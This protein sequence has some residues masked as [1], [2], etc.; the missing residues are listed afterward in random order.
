MTANNTFARHIGSSGTGQGRNACFRNGSTLV[1]VAA[2]AAVLSLVLLPGLRLVGDASTLA[3]HVIQ[4]DALL[5][6]ASRVMEETK[7]S[8]CDPLV[9]DG[10]H[11]VRDVAVTGSEFPNL[12]VQSTVTA[13]GIANLLTLEVLAYQ[14]ANR[15][16]RFDN[17]ESSEALRTQWC[18]P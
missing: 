1:D 17:G 14:D 6:E 3:R 2:G 10:L 13:S 9:F 4:Q 8:L 11:P 15:N 18:R 7:I 16:G 5:F 12:R